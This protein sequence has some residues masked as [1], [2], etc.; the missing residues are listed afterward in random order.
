MKIAVVLDDIISA[1]GG[2]NQALNAIIQIERLSRGKFS[3]LILTSRSENL[4]LLKEIGIEA[5]SFKYKL[6]DIIIGALVGSELLRRILYRFNWISPF[7]KLLS[8]N[9]CDLAYFLAPT[10]RVTCL[11]RINFILT[12]WDNCHRDFPEFPEVRVCGEF[13]RRETIY[14]LIPQAF[15]TIVDSETLAIQLHRRYGVDFDRLLPMPFSQNPLLATYR[16]SNNKDVLETY[17][18]KSGFFL[19]PAQFWP[20]KNHIRIVQALALLKKQGVNLTVV[21]V[22]GDKGNI[23]TVLEAVAREDLKDQIINLGFVS[24]NH[25]RELYECCCAVVMPTYFGPTN[26]PP[27]EAWANHAPLIYSSQCSAQAGDAALLVDPDN[28]SCLAEAMLQLSR[29]AELRERL[30]KAGELRLIEIALQRKIAE[31]KFIYFLS[32]FESRRQC[33][34]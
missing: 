18:L 8:S 25:L 20:H 22:G 33:W 26:L 27:L 23:E 15:L 16:Y 34:I 13:N 21:F 28:A 24:A 1:G 3:C 9:N 5:I 6:L 29:D 19:Y 30:I 10:L 32:Q 2:F 12:I 31:D 17:N 4:P 7:E 11:Q 14:K